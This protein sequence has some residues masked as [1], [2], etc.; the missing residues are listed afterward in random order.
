[1]VRVNPE[2]IR[3]SAGNPDFWILDGND[4]DIRPYRVLVK[5]I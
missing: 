5:K 3:V 4:D 2:K 1:M